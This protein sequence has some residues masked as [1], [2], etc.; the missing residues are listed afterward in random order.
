MAL[1]LLD[2]SLPTGR[3]DGHARYTAA[4]ALASSEEEATAEVSG[5]ARV[6]ITMGIALSIGVIGWASRGAA[7][8]ASVLVSSPAWRSYDLLPVL[9]RRREDADWGDDAFADTVSDA[10]DLLPLVTTA[11]TSRRDHDVLEL[12]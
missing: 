4:A 9:R 10:A 11:G 12:S 1:N 8:M 5:H 6:A 2:R 3:A 7:L